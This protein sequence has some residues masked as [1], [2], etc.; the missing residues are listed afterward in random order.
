MRA[1]KVDD[2]QRAIIAALVGTREVFTP[3]GRRAVRISVASLA[4][5]GGGIPDLLVGVFVIC[6]LVQPPELNLLLEVK[7]K[8]GKNKLTPAQKTFIDSWRGHFAIVHDAAEAIAEVAAH[9]E[10]VERGDYEHSN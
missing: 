5:C 4:K 7:N 3:R 2:N 10:H 6:H 1:A 8:K 9:V